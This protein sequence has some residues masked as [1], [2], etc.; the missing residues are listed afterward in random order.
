MAIKTH[1]CHYTRNMK[2]ILRLTAILYGK[3][4]QIDINAHLNK[5]LRFANFKKCSILECE[6]LSFMFLLGIFFCKRTNFAATG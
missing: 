1:K 3:F 6:N 5:S 4:D 2:I